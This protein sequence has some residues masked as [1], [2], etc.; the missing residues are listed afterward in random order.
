MSEEWELVFIWISVAD[1]C[2]SWHIY[3]N[4][5]APLDE[6][7]MCCL[8]LM[9][10]CFCLQTSAGCC[11]EEQPDGSLSVGR[12]WQL[13]SQD[14]SGDPAGESGRRSHNYPSQKSHGG[15]C[16]HVTCPIHALALEC[17]GFLFLHQG[18]IYFTVK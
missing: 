7:W 15:R 11:Q 6:T 9:Y 13:G 4:S 2:S 10:H 16:V 8:R 3:L 17:L 12:V 18:C 14:L 1:A 5:S